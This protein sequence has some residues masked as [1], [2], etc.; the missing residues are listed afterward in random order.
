VPTNCYGT[1]SKVPIEFVVSAEVQK[2]F[3]YS[4]L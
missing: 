4:I 1:Y 2:P 3:W